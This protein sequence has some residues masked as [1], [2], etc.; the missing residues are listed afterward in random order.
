[1]HR[2]RSKAENDVPR[3]GSSRRSGTFSR[4]HMSLRQ[5]ITTAAA[6]V[7]LVSVGTI[8][9]T[10]GVASGAA[11]LLPC[12]PS[13]SS[14]ALGFVP[15]SPYR[16]AD[17]RTVF[18]GGTATPYNGDTLSAGHGLAIS[19]AGIDG[20][21]A[22]ATAVV[23]N[24]T[25]VAPT[26]AGF[27]TVYD[28]DEGSVPL[29]SNV[30]FAAGQ[31]VGDTTTVGLSSSQTFT[32]YYGPAGAGTANFTADLMG[33]YESG[34][35][36]FYVPVTPTRIY[37][38]R[39]NSGDSPVPPGAGTTL[40]NGGSVNVQVAGGALAS[41]VPA[42]ATAVVLNVGVTD[43]TAFSFMRA[44]PYG[45]AVPNTANQDFTAGETLSSQ[46]I[47]GTGTA[48]AGDTGDYVT[49]ANHLGNVDVVVDV[50]GYY[51]SDGTAAGASLLS[52][53]TAPVRLLDTRPG[54]VGSGAANAPNGAVTLP[55]T[56]PYSA[57]LGADAYALSVGDIAT[58]GNYLTAYA[59]GTTAP[60]VA[61]VNYTPN[62]TYDVVENASYA[63]VSPGGSVS[64]L[65]GPVGAA[66]TNIIVDEDAYFVPNNFT[67]SAFALPSTATTTVPGG[68]I[69]AN[70]TSSADFYVNVEADGYVGEGGALDYSASGVC[71]ASEFSIGGTP[72]LPAGE[73]PGFDIVYTPPA[74]GAGTCTLNV[75]VPGETATGSASIT[76]TAG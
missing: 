6:V 36:D 72:G 43:G 2:K 75:T 44:Y 42:D 49:I 51:T 27:L 3:A 61:T 39:T 35:G 23:V 53:L 9:G 60:V 59:T 19:V 56:D 10:S 45:G 57:G 25:A 31:T 28:S 41:T 14:C 4:W 21:P 7:M 26:N 32:V 38:S 22:S 24:V 62:D 37:D 29:A 70:G 8:L 52:T 64:V 12:A 69:V 17:T 66:T 50:D 18:G 16:L 63:G 1:M 30:D 76:Q 33:Y 5:L 73:S 11:G 58:S 71:D 15:L 47:V 13:D 74:G 40:T 20:V 68:T 55:F 65:N 46:V 48:P 54:G 67:V 34:G